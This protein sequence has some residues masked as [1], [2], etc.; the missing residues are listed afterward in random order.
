VLAVGAGAVGGVLVLL[1]HLGSSGPVV[2]R[3]SAELDGTRWDLDP[4]QADAAAT[5]SAVTVRRDLPARAAT[6]ALATALQESKLRNIDYGDRDSL[7]LFQQRPSQGWGTR[8]E[9]LDP[10]HATNAFLDALVKIPGYRTID[11]TEAAQRV[12]R[13]G[14]PQAY[15]QHETQ[16]RAWASALTGYSPAALTCTLR[17]VAADATP[18]PGSA[19]ARTALTDRLTRDFGDLP[20]AAVSGGVTVDARSLGSGSSADDS[21]VAWAVAQWGVAVADAQHVDR[22]AIGNQLW[23]RASGAWAARPDG[24]VPAG[25]VTI[26]LAPGP[27]AG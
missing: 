3:C 24:T 8:E 20:T 14:Y 18:A 11:I 26:T 23:T 9:I 7:G 22:V 2:E 21:R 15:A 1:N 4:D 12:Q 13:S 19:A 17:P 6:I 25:R 10:V 27:A 16:A 5:V